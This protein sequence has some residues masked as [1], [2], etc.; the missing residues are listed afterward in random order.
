VQTQKVVAVG[1]TPILFEQ[2][3]GAGTYSAGTGLTL[4]GTEFS[5]STSY[6]GQ[7]SLTT[8][9]NVTT[10]TWSA[11]AIGYN[12]GGTGFT[13]YARGDIV[14]ASAANVLAKLTAGVDGQVMQLS[15]GLPVWGDLDGGTY[16]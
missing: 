10:G 6:V 4:N 16:S 1:T 14:Y 8:L 11:N 12:Y 2:F 5:I 15:S 3:S 7:S 13:N 9:G